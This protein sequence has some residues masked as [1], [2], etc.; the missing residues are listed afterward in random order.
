MRTRNALWTELILSLLRSLVW[1]LTRLLPLTAERRHWVQVTFHE[2]VAGLCAT[3][4][5]GPLAAMWGGRDTNASPTLHEDIMYIAHKLAAHGIGT[6]TGG[7]HENGNGVMHHGLAGGNGHCHSHHPWYRRYAIRFLRAIIGPFPNGV[8][9]VG[10]NLTL[11]SAHPSPY[12]NVKVFHTQLWSRKFCFILDCKAGMIVF[13]GG[14][15]TDDEESEILTILKLSILEGRPV[16]FY[17]TA[18]WGPK[19]R[20]RR[21]GFLLRGIHDYLSGLYI[22][23]DDRDLAADTIINFVQEKRE[24]GVWEQRKPTRLVRLLWKLEAWPSGRKEESSCQ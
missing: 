14:I 1:I 9:K 4:G 7:A 16:I 19:L 3:N 8:A 6:E 13:P 2:M 17:S 11:E 10:H 12:Q 15:G 21:E 5:L 23:T 18:Y 24:A 22:E 20:A